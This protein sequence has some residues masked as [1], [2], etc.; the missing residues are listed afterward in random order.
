MC[1]C[2]NKPGRTAARPVEAS[3]IVSALNAVVE[4]VG[5]QRALWINTGTWEVLDLA[6]RSGPVLETLTPDE[7]VD[8]D[9]IEVAVLTRVGRLA[10]LVH[11]A[12]RGRLCRHGLFGCHVRNQ[13]VRP[14]ET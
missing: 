12:H 6:I 5:G 7:A 13:T 10:R 3:S 14:S 1:T 9:T 11:G 8:D 4:R 2:S